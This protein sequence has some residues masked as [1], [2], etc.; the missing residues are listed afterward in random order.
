MFS[1]RTF[2]LKT[3]TLVLGFCFMVILSSGVGLAKKESPYNATQ[4]YIDDVMQ[5]FQEYEIC[6]EKKIGPEEKKALRKDLSKMAAKIFDYDYM[7]RKAVGPYWRV[8][9][10]KQR[11]QAVKLFTELLEENYFG[12]LLKHMQEIQRLCGENIRVM[13]QEMLSSDKAVVRSIIVYGDKEYPVNYNMRKKAGKWQIYNVVIEGVS[14]IKN[15]S[16]QFREILGRN[17][18]KAFL[19][20]LQ[21]KVASQK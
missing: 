17:K 3:I 1:K 13:G 16:S 18:P 10:D 12:K 19:Q 2:L 7:C 4:H 20:K 8:F 11:K 21:D 15:Y 6:S 9:T 5:L 14:L